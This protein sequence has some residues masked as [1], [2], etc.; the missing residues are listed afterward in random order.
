MI[1]IDTSA[2]IAICDKGEGD[3]HFRSV[4]SLHDLGD[5]RSKMVALLPCITEAMYYLHKKDRLEQTKSFMAAI[6]IR[7]NRFLPSQR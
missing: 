5:S 4:K 6:K 2:F 7:R 1:L 3:D